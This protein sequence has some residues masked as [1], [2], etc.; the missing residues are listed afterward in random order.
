MRE[1]RQ[2]GSEAGGNARRP[3]CHPHWLA[4]WLGG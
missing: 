1:V 4:A 2:Q 3:Q